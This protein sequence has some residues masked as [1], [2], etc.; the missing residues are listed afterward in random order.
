MFCVGFDTFV[1]V[2]SFIKASWEPCLVTIGI[3]EVHNIVGVTMA[4]YVKTL[5]DSFSLL[6]KVIAY[7]KNEGFNL[8][9]FIFA[10]VFVIFGF[11]FHLTCPFVESCFGHPMSKAKFNMLLTTLKS[12]LD[13]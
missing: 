7:I 12:M 5:L 3:F 4:N 11:T 6:N 13:F 10:L 9:I 1:I 2:V 8:N